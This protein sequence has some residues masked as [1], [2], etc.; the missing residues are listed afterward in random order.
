MT[1]Q[2]S[3]TKKAPGV[4]PATYGPIETTLRDADQI[5]GLN[6]TVHDLSG[7]FN[8]RHGATLLDPARQSHRRFAVCRIGYCA[9][10]LG[11]CRDRIRQRCL[12]EQQPFVSTCWKGLTEVVVPLVREDALLAILF[13]GTWRGTAP[14][15][16]APQSATWRIAYA[17][18]PA[19]ETAQAERF[20]RLLLTLGT[21]LVQRI[22]QA[23]LAE[24]SDNRQVMIIRF[25]H[26]HLHRD[27]A[28]ADL[29][30]AIHLSPSRTSHLVK[31]LFGSPF[32]ELVIRHRFMPL[33]GVVQR[34]FTSWP[35]RAADS[36]AGCRPRGR[37]ARRR[38]D[39]PVRRARPR[40]VSR[41]AR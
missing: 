38:R 11:H 18:L 39:R 1:Q 32:Q 41:S 24:L 15:P 26:Y 27:I 12:T 5:L 37:A 30:A 16:G 22:E 23:V 29:A 35:P 20:G 33:A 7:V 36:S 6:L 4:H 9:A 19:L 25:L 14:T 40:F 17:R 21:G 28:V 3:R 34:I 2:P 13:A 10:C 31:E 8:V